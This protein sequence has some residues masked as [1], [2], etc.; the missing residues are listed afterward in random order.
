MGDRDIKEKNVKEG[1]RGFRLKC[2]VEGKLAAVVSFFLLLFL[3]L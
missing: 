3:S 2:V 1:L